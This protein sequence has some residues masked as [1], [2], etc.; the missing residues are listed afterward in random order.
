MR[1][2]GNLGE[3]KHKTDMLASGLHHLSYMGLSLGICKALVI[4]QLFY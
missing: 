1:L 3:V 2:N 4:L